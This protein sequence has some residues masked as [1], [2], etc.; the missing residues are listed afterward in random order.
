MNE[1]SIIINGV[2]YDAVKDNNPTTNNECSLYDNDTG[3]RE[4][5]IGMD[6]CERLIGINGIF[7]KSTKSFEK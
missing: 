6:A 3:C 4:C 7:K 1:V 2:R 5:I